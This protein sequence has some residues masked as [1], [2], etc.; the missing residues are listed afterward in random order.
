MGPSLWGFEEREKIMA[1]FERVSGA[2]MHNE[3]Y[4]HWRRASDL[5]EGLADDLWQYTEKF[6][7]FVSEL[8]NLLLDKP[9]LP[10][11]AC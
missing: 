6:P 10:S 3:L 4:P 7:A 9:H 8:E 1:F 5:P 11:T 2:R